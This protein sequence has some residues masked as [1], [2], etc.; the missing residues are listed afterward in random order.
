MFAAASI[1][2]SQN[3]PAPRRAERQLFAA[4]AQRPHFRSAN[5]PRNLSFPE[6]IG[7][8]WRSDP[9]NFKD[10]T[11][12]TSSRIFS[13]PIMLRSV[14]DTPGGVPAR[15]NRRGSW[16]KDAKPHAPG[17]RKMVSLRRHGGNRRVT[18]R[19]PVSDARKSAPDVPVRHTRWPAGWFRRIPDPS[20]APGSWR[21]TTARPGHCRETGVAGK[22]R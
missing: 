22:N 21:R 13:V 20:E 9:L 5:A 17:P 11:H 1:S 10:L 14:A 18:D 4:R 12:V 6:R 16:G 7:R 2:C 8:F 3:W 15:L 19:P